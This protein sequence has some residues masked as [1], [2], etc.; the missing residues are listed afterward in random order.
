MKN[1]RCNGHDH[2]ACAKQ[3]MSK[4]VTEIESA[5]IGIKRQEM[6]RQ[7]VAERYRCTIHESYFLHLECVRRCSGES[8]LGRERRPL[9]HP[10]DLALHVCFKGIGIRVSTAIELREL[11]RSCH[12][13]YLL[14]V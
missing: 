1:S 10:S 4:I 3:T 9:L 6:D 11:Y 12:Y 13:F 2:A 8:A 5:R 14:I 7:I